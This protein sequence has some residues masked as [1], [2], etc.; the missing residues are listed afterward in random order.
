MPGRGKEGKTRL[1]D[2]LCAEHGDERKYAIKL[3]NDALPAATGAPRPGP[4]PRYEPVSEVI[5]AIGNAAEQPCGKRLVE[6]LRLWLPFY[7]RHFAP[8]LPT[9]KKLLGDISAATIDRL[10][11]PRKAGATQRLVRDQ[12]RHDP[13]HANPGG[14]RAME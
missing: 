12:A 5:A 1:L 3:L 2:E 13:A 11:G 10:L 6:A 9:Q 8:L 7:P 4:Q 14:G